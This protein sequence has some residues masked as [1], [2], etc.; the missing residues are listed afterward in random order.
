MANHGYIALAN[1]AIADFVAQQPAGM[2][3]AVLYQMEGDIMQVE[4]SILNIYVVSNHKEF[5]FDFIESLAQ[6]EIN[7][8]AV[9]HK[10][11]YVEVSGIPKA[12]VSPDELKSIMATLDSFPVDAVLEEWL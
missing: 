12:V 10:F 11:E 6:L 2:I 9:L 1:P 4:G 3:D 5:S 8:N 7:L